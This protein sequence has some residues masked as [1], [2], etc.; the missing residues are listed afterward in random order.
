LKLIRSFCSPRGAGSFSLGYHGATVC[1]SRNEGLNQAFK[2]MLKL[3]ENGRHARESGSA[4]TL[5][6]RKFR[7]PERTA[8][9]AGRAS[10]ALRRLQT[11]WINTGTLCNITC[12]NCYIE[13][14]PRND[15]L[16]YLTR[17]EVASY[18]D[19]IERDG[20]RTEEIGFTGGEP[21]MNPYFLSMV[22]DC[23]ARGFRVL[24]LTNAMRPM[25]RVKH[26]L[27]DI[28]DRLG[29]KLTIRVSLDHFTTER[30]EE[31]RG[32]GTFMSPLEGL[33]WLAQSG[34]RVNVAGRT[35]WGEAVQEQRAGYARL[36]AQH[37]IPIDA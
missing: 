18:L 36:F 17:D 30:H 8:T 7:D 14:S 15:R 2:G 21:F 24:V 9:G 5:D 19:E 31:E 3:R 25:Q 28:R 23:L 35:M 16:L 10:V 13:S 1:G 32:P 22:E 4:S 26:T 12:Q 27:L 33:I 34:F 37:A 11:L 6:P 29:D 20:W